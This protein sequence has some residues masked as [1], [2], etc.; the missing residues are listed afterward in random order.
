ME[1]VGVLVWW[2]ELLEW[3]VGVGV[4][5]RG[6]GVWDVWVEGCGLGEGFLDVR[7]LYVVE[8]DRVGRGCDGLEEELGIVG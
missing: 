7:G 5:D 1:M 8:V 2:M 6:Y 4:G 3:E